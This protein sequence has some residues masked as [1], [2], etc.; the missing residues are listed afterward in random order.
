LGSVFLTIL[1]TQNLVSIVKASSIASKAACLGRSMA[2]ATCETIAQRATAQASIDGLKQ[3][4][5]I[6]GDFC[7]STA[8]T[9]MIQDEEAFGNALTMW[10]H[11]L[12]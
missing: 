3:A 10:L 12:L 4:K 6:D 1:F 11:S 2:E 9:K 7:E 8:V 5:R